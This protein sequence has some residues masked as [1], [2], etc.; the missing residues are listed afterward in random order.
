MESVRM[1]NDK[2]SIA[3]A[4]RRCGRP[5]STRQRAVRA[6]RLHLDADHRLD[7]SARTRAGHRTA[8]GALQEHAA[9]ALRPRRRAARRAAHLGEFHG[10]HRE[11]LT[12]E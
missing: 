8:P 5:R 7:A 9:A 2:L 3:E 1:D 4:A 11:A 6:G 10:R 12:Q